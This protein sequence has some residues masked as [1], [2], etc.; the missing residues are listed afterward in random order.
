MKRTIQVIWNLKLSLPGKIGF[1]IGDQD[2]SPQ[3]IVNIRAI[4][5]HG[6][7]GKFRLSERIKI[8]SELRL[9]PALRSTL[10]YGAKKVIQMK[11][12]RADGDACLLRIC[13]VFCQKPK[14]DSLAVGFFLGE[15][16]TPALETLERSF[17]NFCFFSCSLF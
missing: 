4:N 17:S 6:K 5:K 9:S 1:Q 3:N 14:V 16:R 15:L 11:S 10:R 12:A 2:F 8:N 13:I 7:F